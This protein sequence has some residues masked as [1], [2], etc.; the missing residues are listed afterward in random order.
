MNFYLYLRQQ[1][2]NTD[3]IQELKIKNF[4]SFKDEVRFSFE[5]TIDKFAEE[6]QVVT[7]NENTRCSGLL[8]IFLVCQT[9]R[10][11]LQNRSDTI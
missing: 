8:V 6:S 5:A 10:F 7:I 4:L 11:G 2:T 3:M 9:K 1:I